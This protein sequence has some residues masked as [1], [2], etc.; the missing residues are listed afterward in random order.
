MVTM[1]SGGAVT[2]I[3]PL[4]GE[5]H[6][7]TGPQLLGLL[8]RLHRRLGGHPHRPGGVLADLRD[9][10]RR[11]AGLRGLAHRLGVDD[12]REIGL[13]ASE[14]VAPRAVAAF[15]TLA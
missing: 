4:L 1:T 12:D 3:R 14:A 5:G 15:V 10:L 9:D 8:R 13:P 11:V 6:A 7:M 2:V